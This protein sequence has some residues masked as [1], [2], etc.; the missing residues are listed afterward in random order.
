MRIGLDLDDTI[1]STKEMIK[2]YA[3]IYCTENK[4]NL[5][6]LWQNNNY[7]VDF[8]NKYLEEIYAH[9]Q[10]KNNAKQVINK[11]KDM[12]NKIYIITARTNNFVNVNMKEFII[13]YLRKNEIIVDDVIINAKDKVEVCKNLNIDIMLDDSLYNY[14]SLTTSSINTVLYDELDIY[15]DINNRIINWKEFINY[16]V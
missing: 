15:K 10:I 5:D 2:K 13:E 4:M 12:N 6:T 11:L 3:D 1:C 8:L 7:R 16:I 14:N 9:A